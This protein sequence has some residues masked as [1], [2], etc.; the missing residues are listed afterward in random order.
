MYDE[1]KDHSGWVVLAVFMGLV[2]LSIGSEIGSKNRTLP[3]APPELRE[4][5]LLEV[6]QRIEDFGTQ[7]ERIEA[8]QERINY[9]LEKRGI[10]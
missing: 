7:E 2:V 10:E 5:V 1:K 6:E 9:L 8:R 4:Q 3:S